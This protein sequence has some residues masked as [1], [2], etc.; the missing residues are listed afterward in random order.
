MNYPKPFWP[1]HFNNATWIGL[2][3][4]YV[5]RWLWL[6]LFC[7]CDMRDNPSDAFESRPIRSVGLFFCR[8]SWGYGP[9]WDHP[10][11]LIEI[12]VRP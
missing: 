9:P 3:N 10:K 2:L 1:G 4:W 12:E 5:L 8:P 7:T 11:T 6:R